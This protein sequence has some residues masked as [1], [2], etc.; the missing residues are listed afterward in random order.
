M[1]AKVHFIKSKLVFDL[2]PPRM[3]GK[4]IHNLKNGTDK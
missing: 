4:T 1:S 2:D 3:H